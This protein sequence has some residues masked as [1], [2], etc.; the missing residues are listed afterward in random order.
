[1]KTYEQHNNKETY[2]SIMWLN[3]NSNRFDGDP[4]GK[5]SSFDDI[6]KY[7]FEFSELHP[8]LYNIEFK[9][10]KLEETI[11]PKKDIDIWLETKKYNL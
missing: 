9:I 11:M 2:Y 1:M 4:D 5:Y 8:E 7:L 10:I 3:P 6:M